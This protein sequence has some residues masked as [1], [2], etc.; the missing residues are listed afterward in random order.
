M[1][2]TEDRQHISTVDCAL[3][4]QCKWNLPVGPLQS[5]VGFAL[6]TFGT[7]FKKSMKEESDHVVIFKLKV[8]IY[9]K[10]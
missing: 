8:A 10:W 1:F 2:S 9:N 6:C 3:L 4:L 5:C 7:S